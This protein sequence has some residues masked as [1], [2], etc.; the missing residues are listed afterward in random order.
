MLVSLLP[1]CKSHR[2]PNHLQT[3]GHQVS[4][5]RLRE[6]VINGSK[7][8]HRR[9]LHRSEC[10]KLPILR[11]DKYLALL[12]VHWAAVSN[13]LPSATDFDPII[14]QKHIAVPQLRGAS[15]PSRSGFNAATAVVTN[16]C[17]GF[18]L[19]PIPAG[20]VDGFQSQYLR[21][22]TKSNCR[23]SLRRQ[24]VIAKTCP[25]AIPSQSIGL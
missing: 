10:S 11:Q 24:K 21:L 3:T 14:G 5:N 18:R 17:I 1:N 16:I 9:A 13:E 8:S 20:I 12:M 7:K 22:L 4:N 15:K 2:S 25:T 19:S 23:R 6:S